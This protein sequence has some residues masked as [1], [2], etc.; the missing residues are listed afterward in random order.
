V[1]IAFGPLGILLG[2][3]IG[4]VVGE[5]SARRSLGDAGRAGLGA[6]LGFIV[7]A[8]VKVGLGFT[9]VGLFVLAR[10]FQPDS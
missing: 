7:G 6:A 2:P 8:A 5:L 4:A 10:F 9:M 1:G 3:F